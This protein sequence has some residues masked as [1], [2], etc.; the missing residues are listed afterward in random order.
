VISAEENSV[1]KFNWQHFIHG[2]VVGAGAFAAI[3]Y[4]LIPSI[5]GEL[6]HPPESIVPPARAARAEPDMSA[7]IV[8]RTEIAAGPLLDENMIKLTWRGEKDVPADALVDI[9]A[10]AGAQAKDKINRGAVLRRN[11]LR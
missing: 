10:L 4:L 1:R 3:V 7:V 8:A 5:A 6:H 9:R 11:D 2:A